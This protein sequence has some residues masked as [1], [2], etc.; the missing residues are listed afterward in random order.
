M[1]EMGNID[2]YLKDDSTE[3]DEQDLN[4]IPNIVNKREQDEK[5]KQEDI[6]VTDTNKLNNQNTFF[7]KKNDAV[8]RGVCSG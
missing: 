7:S 4:V 1:A 6:Q 5:E 8:T 2:Q 3:D